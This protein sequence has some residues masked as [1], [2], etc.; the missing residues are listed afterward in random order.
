MFYVCTS[1]KNCRFNEKMEPFQTHLNKY[2]KRMQYKMEQLC[3]KWPFTVL[4]DTKSIRNSAHALQD[5]IEELA[6]LTISEIITKMGYNSGYPV[7]R[8]F[9]ARVAYFKT[10]HHFDIKQDSCIPT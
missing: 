9:S 10:F 8:L 1:G 3:T 2:V 7:L 4:Y 6:E 5:P